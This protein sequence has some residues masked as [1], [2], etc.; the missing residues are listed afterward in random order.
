ML[1]RPVWAQVQLEHLAHNVKEIKRVIKPSTK[2]CA[3]IKADGY[4]HGAVAIGQTLID[5]GAD[6]FAVATLSEAIQ[7]RCHFDEMPILILGYTPESMAKTVIENRLIQTLWDYEQA[8]GFNQVAQ[9]TNTKVSV[10]LKIDT[11]MSRVGFQCDSRGRE[12]ALKTARL[13]MLAVEGIY[14]HFACADEIDKQTT[15]RQ[16][17]R[18][19]E[20]VAHLEDKGVVV[21]IKHVSNSAAIIDLPEYNFDMVRAGIMLYGL[22]PSKEVDHS[23]VALKEVMSLKAQLSRVATIAEGEGIS[24]GHIYKT[25]RPMNIGTVPMG[26]ADGYTRLLTNK[27]SLLYRSERIPVVGKICMDQ[28]MVALPDHL[29]AK[30]GDE[31]TL[32]GR[33]DDNDLTIDEVAGWL[34]TINYEIVC[35]VG[36]RVPRVYLSGERRVNYL[37]ALL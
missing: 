8:E 6:Y 26:Y 20:M 32:F 3:V 13:S 31:V 10:H 34:G 23:R 35:M 17:S 19:L 4:G 37:D 16:V 7:L 33:S 14:T 12:E 25:E 29:Q 11:G 15:H 18:F 24:Y 27:S 21:P 1:T 9:A 22:Y 36:K 2:L 30:R 5:N 28:F